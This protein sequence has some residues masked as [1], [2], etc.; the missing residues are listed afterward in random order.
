YLWMAGEPLPSLAP[1][2]EWTNLL[3]LIAIG[4]LATT[5]GYIFWSEA[6]IGAPVAAVA[7]TLLAQPVL[8]AFAGYFFLGER[9]DLWQ[10]LGAL[11]ILAAL[12]LQT[13]KFKKEPI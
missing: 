9:L 13:F 12:A 5:V 8:G 2:R 4:P 1:L 10:A 3:A 11:F 7:L 6:L